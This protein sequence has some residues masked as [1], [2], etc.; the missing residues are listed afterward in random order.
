MKD[1]AGQA[2][3]YFYFEEELG[4]QDRSHREQRLGQGRPVQ[5]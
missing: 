4:R 1:A 2:L 5:I 3:G